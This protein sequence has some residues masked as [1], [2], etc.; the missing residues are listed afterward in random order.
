MSTAWAICSLGEFTWGI[1]QYHTHPHIPTH[2]HTH[3]HTPTPHPAALT[4]TPP[5]SLSP[6]PLPA[7]S[8][9]RPSASPPAHLLTPPHHSPLLAGYEHKINGCPHTASHTRPQLW[10]WSQA[11]RWCRDIPQRGSE[12]RARDDHS[13]AWLWVPFEFWKE[14][15]CATQ[16]RIMYGK[17]EGRRGYGG[18]PNTGRHKLTTHTQRPATT[19]S[20]FLTWI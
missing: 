12:S 4:P 18:K 3:P 20:P 10:H 14:L 9:P 8:P 15:A 7:S 2:T 6:S 11:N 1:V 5:P 16:G 17:Q 13:R 19:S